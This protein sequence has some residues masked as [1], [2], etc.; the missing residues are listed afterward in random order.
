MHFIGDSSDLQN[1][2]LRPMISSSAEN[3]KIQ[4]L[5]PDPRATESKKKGAA[6]SV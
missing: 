1:M 3:S 6:I 4:T 5:G 2:I